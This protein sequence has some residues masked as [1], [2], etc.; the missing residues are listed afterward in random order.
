MRVC[1]SAERGGISGMFGNIVAIPRLPIKTQ[2]R[3]ML[4]D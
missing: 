1:L 2:H 4:L 3:N